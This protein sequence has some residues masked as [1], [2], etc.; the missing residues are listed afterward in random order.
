MLELFFCLYLFAYFWQMIKTIPQYIWTLLSLLVGITLGGF[1][2]EAL[3]FIGKG[4]A[5]FLKGFITIVPVLIFFALSP[6]IASLVKSG[7]GGKLATYVVIIQA[8][9]GNMSKRI[10][11]NHAMT[12]KERYL[13][14]TESYPEI[15]QRVP[16]Y[17]I[18]SYL[19]ITKEFLSSIKKQIMKEAKS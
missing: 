10:V 1:F 14:F 2:P 5:S 9:Y 6:A 19:G 11:R 3:T 7:S 8:A 15:A 12:A 13:L 18:A 4:T 17:M 16:Q